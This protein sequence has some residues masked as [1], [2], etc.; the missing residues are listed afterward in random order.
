MNE[1]RVF[2]VT[3]PADLY[4]GVERAAAEMRVSKAAVVRLAVIEWLRERVGVTPSTGGHQ[5]TEAER[6]RWQR[7]MQIA[8]AKAAGVITEAEAANQMALLDD[9][10]MSMI[11]TRHMED[12]DET[13]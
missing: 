2:S 6:D 1:L 7:L 11:D 10:R 8:Q 4:V 3:L 5:T 12:S 13:S 9:R